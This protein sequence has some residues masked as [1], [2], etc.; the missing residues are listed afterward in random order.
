MG[1]ERGARDWEPEGEA[2]EMLLRRCA[3]GETA[4]F[5]ELLDRYEPLLA[6]FFARALGNREDA[7]EAVIDTFLKVWRGAPAYREGATVRTWLYRIAH[8]TAIDALRRRSR[9]P[10][11]EPSLASADDR[12]ARLDP[13]AD[14]ANPE[15]ALVA[16]YQQERDHRALRLALAQLAPAERTLVVLYYFEG[17]SYAQIGAIT[18]AS[19][20]FIKNRLHR[21]RQRL[22][23]HFVRLRDSDEDLAMSDDPPADPGLDQ[24]RL[25]AL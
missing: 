3:A 17:C 7:E 6:R 10:I 4:A 2:D 9:Q 5:R 21:A 18:G 12:D 24:R 23:V 20:T 16:G 14:L 11:V 22:K 15:A 1:V 19:P 13:V 25:L 8:N